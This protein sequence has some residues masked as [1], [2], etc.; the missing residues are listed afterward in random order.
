MESC[1]SNANNRVIK[2]STLQVNLLDI[3]TEEFAVSKW[4]K[5]KILKDNCQ[6]IRA[7]KQTLYSENG[8]ITFDCHLYQN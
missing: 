2:K 7:V 3:I 4:Q 8:L 6:S 1:I 5:V